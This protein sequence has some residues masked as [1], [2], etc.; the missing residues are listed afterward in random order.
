MPRAMDSQFKKELQLLGVDDNILDEIMEIHRQKPELAPYDCKRQY[1]IKKNEE[2]LRALNLFSSKPQMK[3]IKP[4]QPVKRKQVWTPKSA[5]PLEPS[6]KSARIAGITPVQYNIEEVKSAPIERAPRPKPAPRLT[7]DDIVDVKSDNAGPFLAVLK[8]SS[9]ETFQVDTVTKRETS[10]IFNEISDF[11]VSHNYM[12]KL[13]KV[14][15]SSLTVHPGNRLIVAAG[16]K[17]GEVGL[18]MP[19]EKKVVI[20]LT[21][22]SDIVGG[23]QFSENKLFT[24]SYD[25][26]VRMF[27]PETLQFDQVYSWGDAWF[28]QVN[29]FDE[30][31]IMAAASNGQ[32][33][34]IDVRENN[35]VCA[36]PSKENLQ[37]YGS[38]WG[39]NHNKFDMN[40]FLTT[41]N[42][43][44]IAAWDHR[45]TKHPVDID[46]SHDKTVSSAVFDPIKGQK[47]VSVGF[48]DK[49]CI[50]E[51]E[52]KSKITKLKKFYHA[53]NTGRWLTKF[54]AKWHP[55][56]D[57]LFFIGSMAHPRRVEIYNVNGTMEKTLSDDN[58]ASIQSLVE[59][60]DAEK[61][62]V[63]GNGSGYCYIY[64]NN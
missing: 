50:L 31:V 63:C 62:L 41:S 54:Q 45:N 36:Y 56:S 51:F 64:H 44:K 23:C 1:N 8:S 53:N 28:R 16:S 29:V 34:K 32:V 4:P 26:T 14:R 37:E 48:D 40:Y 39:M 33:M 52:G 60:H 17:Q 30:N 10:N 49:V 42:S 9:R 15:L 38:L 20:R 61:A 24:A 5:V 59:F 35:K 11:H 18:F 19:G 27:D 25:G 22:H 58:I 21:P 43:A 57:E 55:A 3:T 7:F 2:K 47:I 46:T 12:T 6:R 13:C